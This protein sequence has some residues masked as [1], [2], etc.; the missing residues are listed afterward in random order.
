MNAIIIFGYVLVSLMV[1]G[2][3]YI[4]VRLLTSYYDNFLRQDKH[5]LGAKI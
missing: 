2:L 5:N 4:I 1:S 3:L